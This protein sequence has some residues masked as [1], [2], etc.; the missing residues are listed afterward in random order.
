QFVTH[1]RPALLLL[2]CAYLFSALMVLA[3]TLSFNDA[4]RAGR[5]FG[6][7]YSAGGP[8]EPRVPG[9]RWRGSPR[10]LYLAWLATTLVCVL[11][12][13]VLANMELPRTLQ[14]PFGVTAQTISW[15]TIA[16]YGF[17]A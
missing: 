6:T 7:P 5:L 14:E 3:Y 11:V 8:A 10:Q 17:G 4:I 1:R 2:T 15:V 13:F 12:G 9:S 16:L